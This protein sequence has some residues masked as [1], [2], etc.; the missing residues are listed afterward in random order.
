MRISRSELLRAMLASAV[1]LPTATYAATTEE[2]AFSPDDPMERAHPWSSVPNVGGRPLGFTVIGDNTAYA[3]PG[4]FDQAMVQVSWLRPDFVLSVG[5]LI[6][7]Y[8]DD[9]AVIAKQW[10]DVERSIAKLLCPF[11]YCVGNHDLNNPATV[12]AWRQRRGPIYYSFAYKNALFLMLCTED[13]PLA[14]PAKTIPAYYSMV[15]VM[16]SDPEKAMRDMNSFI[17]SPEILSAREI[18]NVVNISDRQVAWVRDILA[19]HP[20]PQWTFVVMHKP[21]WKTQDNQFAKIQAMLADRPHTVIAGHTHYFTHEVIDGHDYIN[22]ATCGGIRQR[23]GPG[24]IDHIINVTLTQNGPLY[25]NIR[26]TGLMNLAGE[27]GQ[28]L[29]Y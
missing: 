15:E 25:A 13:P 14:L 17:A 10:E 19:R 18:A 29:A 7:G 16:N 3:R 6:E 26:L 8:H 5:D 21:G 11:V 1:M 4:V 22:M 12:E 27:S 24:S 2:G 9:P 28:T 20:N 23:P